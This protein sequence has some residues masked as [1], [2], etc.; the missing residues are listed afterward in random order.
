MWWKE[1]KA[2]VNISYYS[3]IIY[4]KCS[5]FGTSITRKTYWI[6]IN[7]WNKMHIKLI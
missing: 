2:S 3:C 1:K 4:K 6:K 7:E 5:I